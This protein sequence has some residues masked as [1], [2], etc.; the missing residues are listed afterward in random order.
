MSE[1]SHG[2]ILRDGYQWE[3]FAYICVLCQR[4]FY[5]MRLVMCADGYLCQKCVAKELQKEPSGQLRLDAIE[6]ASS[7]PTAGAVV[8]GNGH[9]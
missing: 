6:K 8:L 2:F 5:S 1:K 9:P 4:D 3:S 7:P